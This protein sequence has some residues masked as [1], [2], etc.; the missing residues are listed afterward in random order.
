M[1][2]AVIAWPVIL[3]VAPW[4]GPPG[5][6]FAER[7]HPEHI[8]EERLQPPS[9][10][11]WFGTDVHGRD[12]CS[13]VLF[14]ARLSLL[15]GLVG[16]GVSLVIGVLWGAVAGFVG[17]RLDGLMMRAVDV[18]YSMPSIILVIVLITTLEGAF[19]NWLAAAAS[20][21]PGFLR[22]AAFPVSWG[23]ARSPG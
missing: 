16:A 11:H 7:Y 21:A 2:L 12:L 22:A 10:Q 18:L 8:S 15:V 23:S 9:L 20:P 1:V 4:G 6:S 13:R 5:A 14:G 3:N 17:G 19:Q